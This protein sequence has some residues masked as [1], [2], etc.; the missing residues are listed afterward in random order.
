MQQSDSLARRQK[1]GRLQACNPCRRQKLACNHSMPCNRCLRKNQPSQCVYGHQSRTNLLDQSTKNTVNLLA[2]PE[3]SELRE[4]NGAVSWQDIPATTSLGPPT[5]SV[6]YLGFT[7]FEAVYEETRNNLSD[8][9]PIVSQDNRIDASKP[10]RLSRTPRLRDLCLAILQQI[11]DRD[12]GITLNKVNNRYDSLVQK[13]CEKMLPDLYGTWSRYL[14]GKRDVARLESMAQ[15]ICRNTAKESPEDSP[16][17]DLWISNHTGSNLRWD[18]LGV[19]FLYWYGENPVREAKYRT[20]AILQL[21]RAFTDTATYWMHHLYYR[22]TVMESLISGDASLATCENHSQAM[23]FLTFHG[24]HVQPSN[25]DYHPTLQSELT[26]WSFWSSFSIDKVLVSFTGRPPYLSRHYASTALPLDLTNDDILAGGEVLYK[27]VTTTLDEQGWSTQYGLR[28]STSVRARAMVSL[29]RDEL[30]EIALGPNP[31]AETSIKKLVELRLRATQTYEGFPDYLILSAN[32][33][34]IEP[35]QHII[36]TK[37][38]VKLEYLQSLMLID[39]L[40]L[41]QKSPEET[42]LLGVS[43]EI[44]T[45]F[46]RMWTC[47]EK[48]DQSRK[49]SEWLYKI[50]GYG[51]PAGG[52][53]CIELLKPSFYGTHPRHP[54]IT[55]STITQNLSLLVGFLGW[56]SPSAPNAELCVQAKS[57]IQQVLDQ[58]L[59][60]QPAVPST[61]DSLNWDFSVPFDTNIDLMDTFTWLRSEPGAEPA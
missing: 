31:A 41:K 2:S 52:I 61:T 48:F 40:L 59:N 13:V 21:C 26:R 3:T 50:M 39:R 6:G 60:T 28:A 4:D 5:P 20:D 7:S 33:E 27:A 36:F 49:N 37:Q 15:Q 16:D 8:Y 29:L 11:P 23:N 14:A 42:D 1:N 47:M 46:F 54:H 17:S 30:F 34:D 9:K 35:D 56:I 57:T 51:A 53:L 22:R 19:I 38:L 25:A 12:V 24:L 45:L 44:V 55:R 58:V 10:E 18:S 32:E 43:F